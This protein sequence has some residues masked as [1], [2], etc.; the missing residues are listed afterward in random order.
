MDMEGKW[1]L[2]YFIGG[3]ICGGGSAAYL[4]DDYFEKKYE[5]KLDILRQ[6][7]ETYKK[8][9]MNL[10]SELLE[11][12]KE[13]YKRKSGESN[14][15]RDQGILSEED[16]V[17]IKTTW[18]SGQNA[19]D[20]TKFYKQKNEGVAVKE[21]EKSMDTVDSQGVKEI[22][23]YT[24]DSR[25]TK[26]APK[27]ATEREVMVLPDDDYSR[28]HMRYYVYDDKL[29]MVYEDGRTRVVDQEEYTGDCLTKYNFDH[30]E[31]EVLYVINYQKRQCYTIVKEWDTFGKD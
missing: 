30:N 2:A 18:Q 1:W 25:K 8:Q 26:S 29:V 31:Q 27:I 12:K 15:G 10:T 3:I 20:Y 23:K 4:L 13:S 6:N 11:A 17:N 7:M 24:A 28:M 5:S 16:R 19:I 22:Q 9:N 21:P 14:T